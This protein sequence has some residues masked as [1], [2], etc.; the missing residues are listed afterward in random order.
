MAGRK[1]IMVI[2]DD[3]D[4][5]SSLRAVL[6]GEGFIVS[7]QLSAREGINALATITPD[8]ILCDM[9]MERIDSGTRVAD[10]IKLN[11]P[12]IP[13]YLLSS[14]GNATAANVS[15]E[16]LGFDGVFQKPVSPEAL[17]ASIRKT[18]EK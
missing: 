1:L 3:P 9:M 6:E 4:I 8:L 7:T 14:I 17:V 18:L 10:E 13:I 15:I 5:L 11:H 16:Q 2:D 12:S